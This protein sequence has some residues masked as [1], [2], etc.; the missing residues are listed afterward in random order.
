[1]T[2]E[3]RATAGAS[4]RAHYAGGDAPAAPRKRRMSAQRKQEAVLRLLRGE[5]LELVSRGGVIAF[6]RGSKRADFISSND[7]H[8][9]GDDWIFVGNGNDT[10][11]SGTGDDVVFGG[12]GR[13][14]LA[15]EK[16]N[17]VIFGENGNDLLSGGEGCDLLSRGNGDDTL[18][19]A[20]GS[21][22][23]FGG[24]GDDLLDAG[25]GANTVSGGR[26]DDVGIFG[27]SSSQSKFAW[28]SWTSLRSTTLS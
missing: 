22:W 2:N 23:L 16:G 1:M 7:Q 12:N 13:D 15:G 19:G 11:R 18:I 20:E 27:S 25:T 6:V 8:L 21:D 10:V 9:K 3:W 28:L 24:N 4:E 26:G 17:D 5:D 14:E